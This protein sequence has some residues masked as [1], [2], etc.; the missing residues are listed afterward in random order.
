MSDVIDQ[1]KQGDAKTYFC[2]DNEIVDTFMQSPFKVVK[3]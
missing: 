3:R 2:N 1:K